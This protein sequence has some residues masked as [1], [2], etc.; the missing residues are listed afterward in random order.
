ERRAEPEPASARAARPL[1][2]PARGDAEERQAR[3]HVARADVER[4]R[5]Q[6]DEVEERRRVEDRLLADRAALAREH[7][8]REA[9]E[10]DRPERQLERE[11]DEKIRIKPRLV[12][13][14]EERLEALALLRVGVRRARDVARERRVPEVGEREDQNADADD[15]KGSQHDP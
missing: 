4:D 11:R 5:R 10:R 8:R 15:E 14:E 3:D 9:E 13:V 1:G 6:E 12:A 2:E 7:A